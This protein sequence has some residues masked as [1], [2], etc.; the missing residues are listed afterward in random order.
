MSIKVITDSTSDL[1]I[2]LAE[3][4]GITVVPTNVVFGIEQFKD[5][6]ELTADQFYER[7]INGPVHPTTSA[8][9]IGEFIEAFESV[10]KDAD[11]IVSINVSSKL[12]ATYNVAVQA[13]EQAKLNCP[14]EVIDS[15][16]ASLGLG[17]TVIAAAKSANAGAD[18]ETVAEVGREAKERSQCVALF[19]TLEYLQ[20]GGRI[21]K[22]RAFLGSILRIKPMIIIKDG[23]V[24]PLGRARTYAKGVAHI[25]KVAR[26]FG[27]AEELSVMYSTS[28]EIAL[29]IGETMRSI[30][31][32][33]TEPF[34]SRF[35]P[36][37]G[38]H[39]GPG[40]VGISM[41][42]AK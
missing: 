12:S 28:K 4:L 14:I 16:Q 33:G 17:M 29:E 31:P 18:F 37:V 35:G 38:S 39:V 25:E 3:Q 36:S 5:G 6:T 1:P 34:V 32:E 15:F 21:G 7:L 13:A 2:E 40:A 22:A 30:L 19:D 24:Q 10:G 26:E 11:G 9:S 23:E 8:P 42:R 41:L 20:R 27:P